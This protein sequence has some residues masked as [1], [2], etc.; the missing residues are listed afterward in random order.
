MVLYYPHTVTLEA[1]PTAVNPGSQYWE[2]PLSLTDA[3]RLADAHRSDDHSMRDDAI[4][5]VVH[6]ID[7]ALSEKK[8][9]VPGGTC[10]LMNYDMFHRGCRRDEAA[11]PDWRASTLD[12]A[13]TQL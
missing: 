7:P 2:A 6:S 10:V 8:L 13:P 12:L 4:A 5:A 1:G 11:R 3:N 9:T